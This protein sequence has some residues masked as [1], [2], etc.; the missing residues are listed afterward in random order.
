MQRNL[1]LR[2]LWPS[3]MEFRQR[4][5]SI[6]DEAKASQRGCFFSYKSDE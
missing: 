3:F 1:R 4:L 5:G 6:R 2:V